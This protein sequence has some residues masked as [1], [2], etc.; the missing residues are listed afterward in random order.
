MSAREERARAMDDLRKHLSPDNEN[1]RRDDLVA[2]LRDVL[3]AHV[4]AQENLRAMDAAALELADGAA[5]LRAFM[6]QREAMNVGERKVP[7][8]LALEELDRELPPPLVRRLR[9][10]AAP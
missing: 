4:F 1:L 3:Q 8:Q 9:K 2:C 5:R 6:Q 7:W 10:M